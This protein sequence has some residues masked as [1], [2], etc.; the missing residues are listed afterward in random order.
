MQ[1]ELPIIHFISLD[2][3][4]VETITSLFAEHPNVTVTHGN[5]K[6]L[7]V[8]NTVFVSPANSLGYMDGGIDWALSREMFPGV[9]TKVQLIIQC[10][11]L[12]NGF[13]RR[14]LP[15]GSAFCMQ[16][17]SSTQLIVA[18]TMFQ[19][20]DVS[21]TRNAYWSFLAALSVFAKNGCVDA[22]MTLVATGH[23]CGYGCMN[24]VESARQMHAAYID[25]CAGVGARL[26]TELAEDT[27]KVSFPPSDIDD[28]SHG[29]TPEQSSPETKEICIRS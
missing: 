2:K 20:R 8:E 28:G 19:P 16:V 12:I 27:F 29:R 11:G 21:H 25:F 10:N 15:V 14:Y 13:G 26:D 24:P 3:L 22:G 17:R 1:P 23:C 6:S 18:P 7:P 5:I 9:Q 4:W